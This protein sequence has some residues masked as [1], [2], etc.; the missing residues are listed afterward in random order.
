MT[1][2]RFSNTVRTKART[3]RQINCCRIKAKSLKQWHFLYDLVR[4]KFA[5]TLAEILTI[6]TLGGLATRASVECTVLA[7]RGNY[8]RKYELRGR[9]C[10][11][12][13][14]HRATTATVAVVTHQPLRKRYLETVGSATTATVAGVQNLQGCN[15]CRGATIAGVRQNNQAGLFWVSQNNQQGIQTD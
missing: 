13:N 5:E 4:T 1:G 12:N 2:F 11:R 6:W 9:D 10:K 8:A 15:H 7:V 3:K 14:Q